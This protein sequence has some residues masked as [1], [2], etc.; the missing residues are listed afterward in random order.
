MLPTTLG[1]LIWAMTAASLTQAAEPSFY[2]E[3]LAEIDAAI[4]QAIADHKCPG[5]VLWL[6][7]RGV[8]YHKA[9]GSRAL[10]PAAEPMTEDTLFDAASLTKVV[11]CTPAVMLLI[12]R[13]QVSLEERVQT[14]IPEFRGDGKE[15]IT[16]RQLLTHT[17]GLRGDIETRTDWRG[18]PAA[19][20]KACEEKLL[21][22][23]GTA[24][25]YSD[26]N[27]FLLGE[28]VQ[29]VSKTPLEEFVVR[30]I[31]GPLKMTNTMYLPP[32][33][34]LAQIA[35]TEVVAGKP[36][37]GMVHD[38]TARHMGGVA[39]HAGLFTT[40]AD[41]ARYARM[42]LNGGCL[43]E[44][45]VFKRATIQLMTSVQTP[46]TIAARRGLG[47]D[48]DS[49]YS[50]P[51]GRLF[52]IGSYGHTG[53]TGGSFWL[54][55]FSQSFV[56][57]LSNRNHPTEQGNVL[58]LR[59]QLGT[60][61][62]EAI[63]DFNFAYVPGALPPRTNE[64]A[65]VNG[66][67]P[68]RLK[69]ARVLNGIDVLV[70][71]KFD[72]LT[73]KRIGLVTNHTGHDRDRNP[74]I[75]LL[76]NAPEVSLVALFSPEH[77]IRGQVDEAVTDGR[78]E[79]TGL[80]I[81]SLYGAA[82]KPKPE[83]LQGLDA[84]VFDIQDVGCRFYTYTSTMG[85]CLEAAAEAGIKYFVLD[86][87]NPLNGVAVDGPVLTEKTSFVGFHPVPLRYGMT[88]GELARMFNA[89][90]QCHA[91]LTVIELEGWSRDMWLDQT[92]LPW[93]N[94]SPNMR[95]LTQAILYPG[96]GLLESALS[97]GR[98]TDTPFEI[99]G[100]PYIEDTRLAAELNGAGLAGVRFVPIQ[101]TPI[102]SV[103]KDQLCRGVYIMLTDR[104]ACNVVDVG[105]LIAK[106][107]YRWYPG[108]FPVD[109][110]KHLLLHA[111]TL[112]AIKADK[113]LAEIRASWKGDLEE[114]QKRRARYVIYR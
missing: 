105:L 66:T 91:D 53:W 32:P 76:K 93:T 58:P 90:R 70:K 51:R 22:P 62:A 109:K 15:S 24:V 35:P 74:T 28:I 102:Y 92:G 37:R 78:D 68:K 6:E 65:K 21:A 81:Y 114:F 61:T 63:P 11:A 84:L 46:E 18:Q 36:W 26:I 107:L 80:P 69:N 7:H 75:D 52:P 110:I 97:V 27:F 56:I 108:E 112:E 71:N 49:S 50:G 38:P 17:S 73:G 29:R 4:T 113:S 41:L 99:I 12:E 19:I 13:G 98:G 44:V 72:Q 3:K 33:G 42:L 25:R 39:G 104:E 85:L 40:A 94:P 1:L 67:A 103:H 43:D 86:R 95:N 57:F 16:V 30:E 96:V 89:E 59:A 2:P 60:L 23:P 34:K 54:D 9:Y 47:W 45:C 82:R 14:Y 48:I 106:T 5:G 83:Q 64:E 101:F 88:I 20:Q 100:A 10:V 55:P 79:Q 111:A 87:V 77:G 8:S 31:Y